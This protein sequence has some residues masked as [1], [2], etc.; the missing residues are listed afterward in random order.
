MSGR[1]IILNGASSAGKTTLSRAIQSCAPHSVLHV[2]MDKLVSFLPDG[3]ELK[4]EWFRIEKVDTPDGRLPRISNGPRGE[5]LLKAMRRFVGEA[6]AS[7]LDLVV[8]NVCHARTMTDYRAVIADEA[9]LLVKVSA[10]IEVLEAREKARGDRLIGL[11]REQ[12]ANVY[13]GIDY[14]MTFDT[15]LLSS[16][17]IARQIVG[18]AFD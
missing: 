1:V 15:H 7:G 17:A 12:E 5:A 18:R 11:A 3:H 4:P 2:E 8:D 10:P 13:L 14:D 16:E 9:A 6:S